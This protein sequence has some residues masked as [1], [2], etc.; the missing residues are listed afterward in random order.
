MMVDAKYV[1]KSKSKIV[2]ETRFILRHKRSKRKWKRNAVNNKMV[3]ESGVGD[4]LI[5]HLDFK[6]TVTFRIWF[7]I[8]S[9]TQ[10]AL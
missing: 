1:A 9:H 10:R 4:V 6:T 8:H 2:L 3:E 7:R 5:Y